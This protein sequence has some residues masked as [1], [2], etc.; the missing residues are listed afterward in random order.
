MAIVAIIPARFASTRLPGKPLADIHGKTMIEHVYERA[1]AA[2]RVD[3]VLVATD[4]ERIAD[5]VR[6]FGGEAVHDL[7]AITRPAPTASPRRRGRSTP[8]S[9]STCRATSR[10]STRRASTRPSRRSCERPRA[11]RS[12]RSRC[13]SSRRRR[14]ARAVRREGGGRRAR[15][16]RSTSR[17]PHPPRAPRRPRR[18]AGR[19]RGRRRGRASRAS[20]SGSTPTGA[21]RSCAS[22]SLPPHAARAGRGARAAARAR[23][24]HAD[25]RRAAWTARRAWPSTR[26]EDLERVRALARPGEGKK[27]LTKYIFVTGGVVSSLGK[28]L[29][30]ASIGALLEGHGYKVALQKFDPYINVDPGHDEPVPARRGLRHRRRRRDRP[31]PRATTSASRTC[32]DARRPTTGRPARSTSRS[33]RRSGAATTSAAPCRSF[34]TSPTRSRTRSAPSAEDVDVVL[35]EIGGTVGDI[36]SLPFLEAIRQFRQD[37]GPREHALHPPDARAVHRDGRRAEDQADAAQRARPARRSAS[38]PTSCSAAPTASS[39]R[40]SSA[41]IA[42]FC[43]VDEEAVIT[44]KDVS[45]DLRGAARRSPP[46]ASTA[47][48]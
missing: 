27:R 10:C 39:T 20:T 36:E 5:V 43:D 29:A 16:T 37:V 33:S 1:R 38:S 26:R 21:R 34:R 3:R 30:A 42:L 22:P 25:P 6:A 32:V 46:R 2:Q 31:R 35:V 12:R 47:S 40:T 15:A 28:G 7:A 41:K 18:P 44:A 24:R 13:R 17:A 19:G 14:D 9:S 23:A 8:R 45:S 11:R 48:S 4:D